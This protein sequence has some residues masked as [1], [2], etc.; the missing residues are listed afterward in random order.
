MIDGDAKL[1]REFS[2]NVRCTS[3]E[4]CNLD[5]VWYL[6]GICVMFGVRNCFRMLIFLYKYTPATIFWGQGMKRPVVAKI[7]KLA[8]EISFSAV[9]LSG[10]LIF[11]CRYPKSLLR[12]LL[13]DVTIYFTNCTSSSYIFFSQNKLKF[14][15]PNLVRMLIEVSLYVKKLH[16]CNNGG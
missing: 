6:L 12:C 13:G 5:G 10:W 14:L 2:E 15:Q 3:Q 8:Q 16:K 11:C 1:V 7:I 4:L 9:L